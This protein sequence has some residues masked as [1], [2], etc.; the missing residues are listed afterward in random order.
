MSTLKDVYSKWQND[1][2]FRDAFKKDPMTALQTAK[3]ELSPSDLQKAKKLFA[4]EELAKK[5]SK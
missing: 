2:A 3:F 5:I 4:G 1:P